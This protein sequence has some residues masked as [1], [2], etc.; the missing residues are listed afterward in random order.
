MA[1]QHAQVVVRIE[2]AMDVDRRSWLEAKLDHEIGIQ[3]AWFDKDD[4]HRLI[5]RYNPER[6]SHLTLLDILDGHGFRGRISG[7]G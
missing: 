7:N 3:A 6:F 1:N 5:I 4:A 2:Q